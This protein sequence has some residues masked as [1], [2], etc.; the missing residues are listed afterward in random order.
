ML[1][2]W[3]TFCR[4]RLDFADFREGLFLKATSFPHFRVFTKQKSLKKPKI[5]LFRY[6]RRF[7]Q[8]RL[9][10]FFQGRFFSA[11]V[12]LVLTFV[13]F[14]KN[15]FFFLLVL[16]ILPF[17]GEET[18]FFDDFD[19]PPEILAASFFILSASC[20]KTR[21]ILLFFAE[22]FTPFFAPLPPE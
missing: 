21:S 6:F 2:L 4:K 11:F 8:K 15:Y 3:K 12:F 20:P 17:L 14:T 5:I 19:E 18:L 22:D 1:N 7:C 13:F 16:L 9:L 10:Q